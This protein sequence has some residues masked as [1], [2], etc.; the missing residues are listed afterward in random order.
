MFLVSF[1]TAPPCQKR[2]GDKRSFG[3][4]YYRKLRLRIE[5]VCRA[6]NSGGADQQ[7]QPLSDSDRGKNATIFIGCE[8]LE[9]DATMIG[10]CTAESIKRERWS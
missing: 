8:Q 4:G 3:T 2:C 5:G 9:H 6:R 7:K 1:D 10:W